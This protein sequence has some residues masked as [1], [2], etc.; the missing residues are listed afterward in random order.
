MPIIAKVLK[1]DW[2]LSRVASFMPESKVDSFRL[3][4]LTHETTNDMHGGNNSHGVLHS[5]R[6]E[7]ADQGKELVN[8][9]AYKNKGISLS[10]GYKL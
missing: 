3:L 6:L 9:C 1:T 4:R 7:S 8:G 2:K 10:L 5:R